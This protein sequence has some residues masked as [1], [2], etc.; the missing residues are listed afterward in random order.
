MKLAM[1]QVDAFASR[2]FTG[3][4][5]AVVPLQ[6]WLP[7]DVMQSIALENNLSET[8]YFVPEE[9]GYAIRWFTPLTEVD[10]CGHATLASAYVVFE[11]LEFEEPVI[12]FSSRSG[13]LTVTRDEDRLVLDFPARPPLPCDTPEAIVRAFGETPQAC[14]KADDYVIV[15]ENESQVRA[16]SPNMDALLEL[17]GRGV[18]ITSRATDCDFVCR[19]FG[20]AVGIPEDPVTGSAYTQLAPYWADVLGKTSFHARQLS[21]RGGELHCE[22][23]GDRV[24]IAGHATLYLEGTIRL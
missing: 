4:P 21:A 12:R 23:S 17:D 19:F 6:S 5:A 14:L 13:P 22:V 20:P 16:A 15:F 2:V 8:A 10:L 24:K 3:N 1:Y 9:G 11:R 18:V 7:D